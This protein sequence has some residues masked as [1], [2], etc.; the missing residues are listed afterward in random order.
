[1][2]Q[3]VVRCKWNDIVKHLPYRFPQSCHLKYDFFPLTSLPWVLSGDNVK[4]KVFHKVVKFCCCSEHLQKEKLHPSLKST[5]HI[6]KNYRSSYTVFM[7][8]QAGQQK[9]WYDLLLEDKPWVSTTNKILC[10]QA[11][12]NPEKC[13]CDEKSW[14]NISP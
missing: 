7:S 1:M 2:G 12:D 6:L 10:Y 4:A 9:T 8:L 14:Q 11:P 5:L 3:T 13:H